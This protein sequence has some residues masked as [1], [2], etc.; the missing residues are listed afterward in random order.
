MGEK[1]ATKIRQKVG[2]AYSNPIQ[3]QAAHTHTHKHT[4]QKCFRFALTHLAGAGWQGGRLKE[5]QKVLKRIKRNGPTN[6]NGI[7]SP[8]KARAQLRA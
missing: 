8:V 7:I 1:F 6:R 4:R 5:T 3:L 2:N